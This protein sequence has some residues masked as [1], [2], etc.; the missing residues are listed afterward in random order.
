MRRVSVSVPRYKKKSVLV[1][2]HSLPRLTTLLNRIPFFKAM[3]PRMLV[4]EPLCEMMPV[5]PGSVE[6]WGKKESPDFGE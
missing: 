3:R 1:T 5:C 2:S 6:S 4:K